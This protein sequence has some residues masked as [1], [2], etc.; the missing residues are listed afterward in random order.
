[1]PVC[2]HTPEIVDVCVYMYIHRVTE[3][4]CYMYSTYRARSLCEVC[5]AICSVCTKVV[6][7]G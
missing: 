2:T 4:Q 6:L 5:N 3:H 7:F 1:M